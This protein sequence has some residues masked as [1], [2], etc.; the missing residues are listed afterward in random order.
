MVMTHFDQ[1][2]TASSSASPYAL[3]HLYFSSISSPLYVI[4]VVTVSANGD[5]SH[6]QEVIENEAHTHV[7]EVNGNDETTTTLRT[8]RKPSSLQLKIGKWACLC[9]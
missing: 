3:S 7:P 5:T 6:H 1:L 9:M 4:Q 8:L 2:A